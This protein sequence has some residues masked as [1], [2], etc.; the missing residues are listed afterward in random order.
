MYGRDWRSGIRIH[1]VVLPLTRLLSRALLQRLLRPLLRPSPLA[2]R[3]I[4]P[5]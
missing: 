2:T 3:P 4:P 5:L 1:K